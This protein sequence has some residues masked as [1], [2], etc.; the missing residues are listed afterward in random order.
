MQLPPG[1]RALLRKPMAAAILSAVFPGVGQAAAGYPIRGAI[2]A[3]PA[4]TV[5]GAFLLILIVQGHSILD[6]AFN[7]QWLTSLLLLDLVALVYHLWAV[8]D[9][10]VLAGR[11]LEKPRR[12]GSSPRKWGRCLASP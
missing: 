4:L 9:T 6:S 5:V 10:Y 1:L 8:L 11:A 3:I 2:V 12:S 7:Q